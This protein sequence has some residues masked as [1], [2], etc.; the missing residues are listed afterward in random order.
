MRKLAL[1]L[2]VAAA[3]WAQKKPITLEALREAPA[4]GQGGRVWAPGGK[5][6]AF[7]QN[8]EVKIY[9]AASRT[10]KSLISI[11]KLEAA[12]V[13]PPDASGPFDWTNRY[14]KVGAMAWSD[15]GKSL[16][17]A[18]QGDVFLI[19]VPGGEMDQLTRTRD[20]EIAPQLSPD[21][22]KVLFRRG[23]DLY[24]VDVSTRKET[25]L[26]SGGSET[27][28][29]GGLDWVYPE[30]IGLDTAFWWS[31]DSRWVA[32][33]QFDTSREP[34]FPH[35]DLLGVHPVFEPERYPQAGQNNATVRL[36]IVPAAGGPT[37]WIDAATTTTSDLLARAGW[38]PDARRLYIVRMNRVQNRLEA[39]AID[40]DSGKASALFRES[41]PY[42]LNLRG[43]LRFVDDGKRFLWTSEHSGYRQVYLYS[44]DGNEVQQ[45]THG[46]WEIT[47]IAAV[48]ESGRR[49]FYTSS[50]PSPLERHLYV[51]GFDGQ[52]K[53]RLTE[54]PGTHQISMA[55]G[56]AYYLDTFSNLKTPPRIVLHAGDGR[57]LGVYREADRRETEEYDVL[58]AEIVQFHGPDGTL[59]N[60]RLIRPAGYQPGKKYPVV[61]NVYGGPDAA[62]P[63]RDAW[64]GIDMDQVLAH[65]G[66]VVWQADN[67]GG[68]GRG[69]AFET[70][71]FHDLGV[72]ELADQ[73][74]G[75]RHLISMGLADPERIGIRGHSYG[76]FMTVNALLN[77]PDVF[78]AGF[79][80]A[81]V[82]GWT[83]YD[84]I[85]TERYMGLPQEDASGYRETALPQHAAN[86]KGKL[87]LVHNFEDDN[88]L[89]QN[90]LQLT[91]ALEAAGKQ[92][93][94]MLYSQKTHGITGA[95]LR[96]ENQ[97]MLDF[98]DRAL[99][100][101]KAE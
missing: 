26:T 29:N 54:E 38:M 74:A 4:R 33:L 10:T 48:D 67:R 75:V 8:G 13:K 42:W 80:G 23:W 45:V 83:N 19:R 90:T 53:R 59:L 31:P 86:L 78:H 16:L 5:S 11:D 34:L 99:R 94:M 21:G 57:A 79:A 2:F 63:A 43:D 18:V 51:I 40:A 71:I 68:A 100:M 20:I 77:A 58:P 25:R 93:E 72:N 82:T 85:Y 36:G 37:R 87:M 41:D 56:G 1:V 69:H 73:V 62:L 39:L 17:Y 70:A 65:R 88:V 96:H 61:V 89:V 55:P 9:D 27:Q 14:A 7:R 12:A 24:A 6:F 46:D 47:S 60:G 35:A 3:V 95:S 50:E 64:P 22:K 92:F 28:R 32:Y 76:G 98:F 52:N 97:L 81:P 84:T 91:T 15:D 101:S 44:S 30:E 49:I 66:Y